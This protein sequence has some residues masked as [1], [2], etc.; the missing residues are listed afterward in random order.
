MSFESFIDR[1]VPPWLIAALAVI[2]YAGITGLVYLAYRE[3]PDH[4]AATLLRWVLLYFVALVQPAIFGARIARALRDRG[5]T[6]RHRHF[7]T[8]APGIVGGI[9][10]L[11]ALTLITGSR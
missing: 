11:I 10:L 8:V 6:R 5:L 4:S 3:Y 2:N 1:V 9:T 7:C